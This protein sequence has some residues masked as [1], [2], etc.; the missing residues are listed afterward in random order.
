MYV[1]R[2]NG[3]MW[4]C[5]YGLEQLYNP[6]EPQKTASEE[7]KKGRILKPRASRSDLHGKVVE[8]FFL[9]LVWLCFRRRALAAGRRRGEGLTVLS[10]DYWLH[11][12][13]L[14]AR[15]VAKPVFMIIAAG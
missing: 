4:R 5:D 8:V 14:P 6:V 3:G 12:R 7:P 15:H 1:L 10:S 11:F 13:F 2:L 9:C